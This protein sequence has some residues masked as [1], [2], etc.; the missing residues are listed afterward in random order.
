[1]GSKKN[2]NGMTKTDFIR[3]FPS[4]TPTKDIV[5]A[6][7]IKGIELT[8]GHIQNVRWYDK[9]SKVKKK[10]ARKQ[11]TTPTY[12]GLPGGHLG[13]AA[14]NRSRSLITTGDNDVGT[15]GHDAR[16]EQIVKLLDA[17]VADR[18]AG[19]VRARLT[20]IAQQIAP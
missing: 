6:A 19:Q 8:A 10:K 20:Q 13:G 18:V 12:V 1:M 9:Q 17:M 2:E 15:V 7:K 14:A 4:D 11:P 3:S 5:E 16:L